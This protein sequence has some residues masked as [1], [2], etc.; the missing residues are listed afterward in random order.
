MAQSCIEVH[1]LVTRFG[2]Y[3]LQLILNQRETPYCSSKI[4]KLFYAKFSTLNIRGAET[5]GPGFRHCVSK[6]VQ[7]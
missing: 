4:P 1:F 5:A 3:L 2:N 6:H 7:Q